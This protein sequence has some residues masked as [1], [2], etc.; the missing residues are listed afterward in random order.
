ML[1]LQYS[2]PISTIPECVCVCVYTCVSFFLDALMAVCVYVKAM[3]ES[4]GDGVG[5]SSRG[6]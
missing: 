3:G 1:L 2:V 5:G 6:W 4:G